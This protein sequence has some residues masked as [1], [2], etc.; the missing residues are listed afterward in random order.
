LGTLISVSPADLP[1]SPTIVACLVGVL[2][3][4]SLGRALSGVMGSRAKGAAA[5]TD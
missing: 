1:T 5:A 2:V 4:A 3:L